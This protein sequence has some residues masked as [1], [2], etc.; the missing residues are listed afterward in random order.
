MGIIK[1]GGKRP[2]LMSSKEEASQGVENSAKSV[3]ANVQIDEST[4]VDDEIQFEIPPTKVGS[5]TK[6]I[7]KVQVRAGPKKTALHPTN[8]LKHTGEWPNLVMRII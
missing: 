7:C 6:P 8:C 4:I 1:R 5:Q 3:I 2:N